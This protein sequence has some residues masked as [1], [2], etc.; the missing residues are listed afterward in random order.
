MGQ[1]GRPIAAQL[2]INPASLPATIDP[3]D[4]APEY[5]V[6]HELFHG[7][8][9]LTTGLGFSSDGIL[10]FPG[11]QQ[12]WTIT[13]N[14]VKYLASPKVKQLARDHF[15]CPTLFGAELEGIKKLT[16]RRRQPDYGWQSLGEAS[17]PP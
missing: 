13:F 15:D 2:N 7:N 11:G 16:L 8:A 10:R 4:W 5:A 9:E 12:N 1:D 3:E 14:G 6:L 17:V